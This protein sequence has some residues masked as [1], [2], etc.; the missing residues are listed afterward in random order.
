MRRLRNS[1]RS[2]S[3]SPLPAHAPC[4]LRK[5]RVSAADG[6]IRLAGGCLLRMRRL[7]LA[8]ACGAHLSSFFRPV[9]SPHGRN[10]AQLRRRGCLCGGGGAC[11]RALTL[12]ACGAVSLAAEFRAIAPAPHLGVGWGG[13]KAARVL[14]RLC[15]HPFPPLP[16]R[17]GG[18]WRRLRRG[19]P[20]PATPQRPREKPPG[21]G[22]A[23][24]TG[25]SAC[26]AAPGQVPAP[27]LSCETWQ[28]SQGGCVS[29]L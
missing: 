29:V 2:P 6:H 4:S 16:A 1:S 3:P 27:V 22:A 24:A 8:R 23:E 18:W 13:G 25:A 5:R 9:A 11:G 7:P 20:S 26:G 19:L 17:A 12:R 14:V 28:R 21:R 10:P 15:R